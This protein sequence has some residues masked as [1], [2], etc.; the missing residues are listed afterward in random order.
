MYPIV[1]A[2]QGTDGGSA[3]LSMSIALCRKLETPTPTDQP[4]TYQTIAELNGF[5][6][7]LIVHARE[8]LLHADNKHGGIP[9]NLPTTPVIGVNSTAL[10]QVNAYITENRPAILTLDSLQDSVSHL[11]DHVAMYRNMGSSEVLKELS[12]WINTLGA[13]MNAYMEQNRSALTSR[14]PFNNVQLQV[15]TTTFIRVLGY[16]A[17]GMEAEAEAPVVARPC[18]RR[19]GSSPTPAAR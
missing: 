9:N 5:L 6:Q 10:D 11:F 7:A 17:I 14:D 3:G 19:S 15:S 8:R 12:Q 18:H 1:M 4:A 13:D 16:N 2:Q